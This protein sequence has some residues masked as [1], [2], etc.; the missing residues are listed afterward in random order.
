[1]QAKVRC[2]WVKM[3]NQ[4]YVDYHDYEWGKPLHNDQELFELLCL[5]GAQAGLSWES[6]LNRREEYRKMFWNFDVEKIIR[7]TDD[8]LLERMQKYGIIKN[9]LKVLGV[10]KNAHAYKK[11]V[12][13][14][15]SLDT[16]LWS[17][18]QAKTVKNLWQSYRDAPT[19]TII[20][21]A[22]SKGLKEYGCTFVSPT[23]CYA[24]M[25]ASGLVNDH[26]KSCCRAIK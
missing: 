19:Q 26:E 6:V 3:K 2:G 22:M 15:G 9:R 20:S 12:A 1:M 8:A 23:I 25:Q 17:F 24:F 10:K 21:A 7:T 14:Y 4:T 18:V 11:I 13:E 16:Y 5:E